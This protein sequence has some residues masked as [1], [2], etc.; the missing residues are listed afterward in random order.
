V[1]LGETYGLT[2]RLAAGAALAMMVT[3][4]FAADLSMKDAP[5]FSGADKLELTGYAAGTTDYVFRGISQNRRAPTV[6]AEVDGT[7]GMFYFGAFAS[8]INFQDVGGPD[9]KASLEL[10]LYGGIKP[11]MGDITFD[12]GVIGYIYPGSVTNHAVGLF[13][14]SYVEFKAGASTTVLKDVAVSGT[15]FVSPDYAG[16]TGTSVTVEGTASKPLFKYGKFDFAAS[17][18]VGHIFFDKSLAPTFGGFVAAPL[19]SYTYGNLGM[20][21]T[22]NT[23]W[24]VDFRWWDTDLSLGKAPCGA[25]VSVFQCGSALSATAKYS[26]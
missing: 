25:D 7:Y 26:W 5:L 21:V 20:T 3:P 16:E 9:P 18:T 12:F 15:V 11:K 17:G 6:Q 22:W 10:D 14:P 24:S 2:S 13:D 4:G 19:E 23:H 8:G 1:A